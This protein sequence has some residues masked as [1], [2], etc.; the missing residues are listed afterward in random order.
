MR[1]DKA[2][3]RTYH[4]LY[5]LEPPA[6]AVASLALA[7]WL[8]FTILLWVVPFFIFVVLPI[9]DYRSKSDRWNPDRVAEELKPLRSFFQWIVRSYMILQWIANILAVTCFITMPHTLLNVA[10]LIMSIGIINGI[11]IAPAHELNHTHSKV[12][13][14]FSVLIVAPAFYGQFLVEH[15]R[16]HH[17]RVATPEDPAS[18][19]FGESFWAFAV[20]SVTMG[21]AS[22]CRFEIDRIT[23]KP[24]LKK[25][26]NSRLLQGWLCSAII[27]GAVYAVGGLSTLLFFCAQAVVA[28][29]LL[30]VVNYIEHYGLLRRKVNG[31]YEPCT[32]QHS[33]NSNKLVTNIGLFNLQRHSD[34]HANA[35]RPYEMLRHFEDSPQHP[36]GYAAMIVLALIPPLWFRVMNQRVLDHYGG[37]INKVNKK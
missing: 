3:L 2:R 25:V 36:T 20:R 34:H 23:R 5:S 30:E 9:M 21:L 31:Q 17:A 24:S 16:G 35:M 4:W 22:A 10:G 12:N 26:L 1:T 7:F 32:H 29:L 37:D 18:A 11:A 14:F 8:K 15:N 6:L 27:A 33:W 13:R 19:R 28:I